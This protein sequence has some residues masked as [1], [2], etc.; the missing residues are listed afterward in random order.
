MAYDVPKFLRRDGDSLLFNQEGEFVFYVP[1]IYFD[2][3]RKDAV[4][5]GEYV[6]LL[7]I[8]DY[9]IFSPTGYSS[10]PK[11]FFFPTVF[12]TRPSRIEKQKNVKL[13]PGVDPQDYRLLIYNKD[14]PVVVSTKVPQDIANVE[15][16]YRIFLYG[17]LPVT[18][19]Y[20][21]MQDY[22]T[23]SIALNGSSYSIT[24][25]MFGF[26]I[27]EIC[28]SKTN[29]NLPFRLT[30]FTDLTSYKPLG[31]RDV[32]KYISPNS[33]IG[34]ENWDNA[35]V[36]A[37]MHPNDVGSPMEKLIMGSSGQ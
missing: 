37:I 1:E 16:F 18:I 36:G 15:S 3:G 6:N 29:L 7:G 9:A 8:L 17:K 24:L 5:N 28:R 32:P 10:G 25:Q 31:I 23:E 27:G 34:S 35:V 13:K 14:D 33:S 22:F 19:P 2:A 11:R 21:K 20:D 26:V 4:I 12:L 30:D